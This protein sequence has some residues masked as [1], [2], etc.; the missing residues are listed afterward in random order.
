VTDNTPKGK[1]RIYRGKPVR[2]MHVMVKPTGAL[3]NLLAPTAIICP[4]SSIDGPK[5]LHDTFRKD[6]SGQGSFGR[7]LREAKLLRKYKVNFATLTCVNRVNAKHPLEVYR[8]LRDTV[9]SKRIQFILL[10]GNREVAL[11]ALRILCVPGVK[12]FSQPT[13]RLR[14][15]RNDYPDELC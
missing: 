7:V 2:R 3:C 14:S 9:K 4:S 12:H 10:G 13:Q 11:R 1:I 15:V 8:F 5:S 6:K